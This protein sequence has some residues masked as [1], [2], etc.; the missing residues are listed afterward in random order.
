MTLEQLS[1]AGANKP[2][3]ILTSYAGRYPPEDV[4]GLPGFEAFREAIND[5][6]H[7]RHDEML[8]WYGASFDPAIVDDRQIASDLQNLHKVWNS[9]RKSK[10]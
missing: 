4:G 5:P 1:P 6:G 3:P 8:Q 10:A 2:Y 9:P 7:E